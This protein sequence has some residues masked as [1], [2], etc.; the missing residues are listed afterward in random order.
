[1][2]IY[3]EVVKFI[4][5]FQQGE[6][7]TTLQFHNHMAKLGYRDSYQPH[8]RINTYRTYL[9]SAG[10]T[11]NVKRGVWRVNHSIPSWLSLSAL[12]IARGYKGTEAERKAV[13]ANIAQYKQA[14]PTW[15]FKIGDTVQVGTDETVYTIEQH[16]TR[17]ND[18]YVTW[19]DKGGK[20][21][22]A[23]TKA[24]INEYLTKKNPY[25]ELVEPK[26]PSFKVGDKVRLI[27]GKIENMTEDGWINSDKIKR[28]TTYTVGSILEE[29]SGDCIKVKPEHGARGVY[30]V[31]MKYF[32]PA[33]VEKPAPK[34]PL[35]LPKKE[36]KSIVV[37]AS[38]Q[39]KASA[40]K[41][42][43]VKSEGLEPG[44]TYKVT[45]VSQDNYIKVSGPKARG[46]YWVSMKY[47][48]VV[49]S[50]SVKATHNEI[51]A[52]TFKVGD[53]VRFLADKTSSSFYN[54]ADYYAKQAGLKPTGIYTVSKVSK[55]NSTDTDFGKAYIRLEGHD[56]NH[57]YDCFE[58]VKAEAPKPVK[59]P[60]PVETKKPRLMLCVDMSDSSSDYTVGKVY[61]LRTEDDDY[62][63]F[64]RDDTGNG[65]AGGMF[66]H[67][68]IE[69]KDEVANSVKVLCTN[70][71]GG[72]RDLL[73]VGKTYEAVSS[74]DGGEFWT[75]PVS[76]KGTRATAYKHRFTVV[77]EETTAPPISKY[78]DIG[79]R[80]KASTAGASEIVYLIK[81]KINSELVQV[82]W[83]SPRDPVG[84]LSTLN[85]DINQVS[86]HFAAGRWVKI[87]EEAP[88]QETPK[89]KVVYCIDNKMEYTTGVLTIGKEY[90]V[91]RDDRR[92]DGTITVVN[93]KGLK[94]W[95]RG[96]RFSDT[97]PKRKW[98]VG[99]TIL[100]S[101]LNDSNIEKEFLGY[102][103]G[104]N[105]YSSRMFV[106]DRKIEVILEKEGKRAA[107]IS[108]TMDIW[109]TL[110]SLEL[111]P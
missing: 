35:D 23:Y 71:A 5:S 56:Y 22:V 80:F 21:S 19:V 79:D 100:S 58:L 93:D 33:P 27:D 47:F 84:K 32:V 76:D 90:E 61:E 36:T 91:V 45:E 87:T 85:F 3:Q 15:A 54:E 18:V 39:L 16:P 31:K 83:Q 6:T 102:D 25:W 94:D 55:F 99:D 11:S 66:K 82:E 53:K 81:Q 9:R 67:R 7:F 63:Y 89:K 106:K 98:K 68:F 41:G 34:V 43:W 49:K 38:V 105:K 1:M 108:G 88:K 96:S 92:T 26:T 46:I 75:I 73:T 4:N 86:D 51:C 44:I 8:Y 57:P 20:Q 97:N 40:K 60:K 14:Q 62:Y 95:Y 111:H 64:K 24:Q 109:I 29:A 10:F 78:F 104:W 70:N 12:E 69:I 48:K 28:D 74:I 37:G 77:T 2:N 42:D 50:E 107:R 30:W 52:S 65:G 72:Y 17:A 110:E 101:F 59:A 13:R 103:K